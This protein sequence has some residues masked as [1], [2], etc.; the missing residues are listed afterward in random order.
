MRE[1]TRRHGD[2]LASA[3]IFLL[4]LLV[5]LQSPV[6][7]VADSRYSLVLTDSLMRHGT[8]DLAR[9]FQP[10]FDPQ[11]FPHLGVNGYPLNLQAR[12]GR[13]YYEFP[14]GTPILSAPFVIL[15]HHLGVS[16]FYADGSYS[17]RGEE[18]VQAI[19]AAGLMAALAVVWYLTARLLLPVE[20]SVAIAFAAALGT[21]VWSTASR[22]LWSHTWLIFL[23]GLVIWM[24]ARVEMQ[25]GRLHPVLLATLLSWMYF[26]RPNASIAII[27]ITLYLVVVRR[28]PMGGYLLTGAAWLIPFVAYSQHVYGQI[29]PPYY[30]PATQFALTTGFWKGL[31]GVLLSPSRGLFP[32]VP[33]TLFVVYLVVR[34]RRTLR[35]RSLAWLG[36]SVI[37]LQVGLQAFYWN[38]DGATCIGPRLLT[39]VVPWFVLLAI[40][41]VRARADASGATSSV[42]RRLSKYA[43][44][45][46]GLVLLALSV[47]IN[48]RSATSHEVWRWNAYLAPYPE[49]RR[50]RIMDWRYPQW[51]AGMIP[52]PFPAHPAP[53]VRGMILQL[54]EPGSEVF[55]RE[56]FGW[57]GG[58]GHFRRTDGTSAHVVFQVDPVGAGLLEMKIEP[59]LVPQK[60]E[61]QRLTVTLNGASLATLVLR[62]P[63]PRTYSMPIPSGVLKEDS[64]LVLDLPDATSLNSLRLSP[65]TRKLGVKLYWLRISAEP[66]LS[67][68]E[69]PR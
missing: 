29:L 23:L 18:K 4:A 2:K 28:H 36:F 30:T 49:E 68:P 54:G 21:Q 13:V 16:S 12:D 25:G 38:W 1:V 55:L 64:L 52:P 46:V 44:V 51:L 48:G 59:F 10:P 69:R 27:A 8:F 56:S 7:Q 53:Y 5:F 50:P 63:E 40:L 35:F 57:S 34:Y 41:G 19:V 31:H 26:V 65:D 3:A 11:E 22:A 58:E 6:H 17:A 33:I 66:K 24:L 20:A 62:D 39:D 43:E 9:Y 45:V 32:C 47:F 60:V 42:P 61:R 14:I 67:D 15:L 37:S